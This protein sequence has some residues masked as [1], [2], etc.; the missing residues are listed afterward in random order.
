MAT[1]LAFPVPEPEPRKRASGPRSLRPPEH[2]DRAFAVM[3]ADAARDGA[4]PYRQL[5][6][7][8]AYEVALRMIQLTANRL[9]R[10]DR[11]DLLSLAA[12]LAPLKPKR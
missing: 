11:I 10:D 9:Y 8:D 3:L 1:V 6:R 5:S 12:H 2:A 4:K 7:C